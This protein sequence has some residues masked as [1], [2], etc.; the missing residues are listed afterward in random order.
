VVISALANIT[1][2]YIYRYMYGYERYITDQP[3]PEIAGGCPGHDRRDGRSD[4]RQPV[5]AMVFSPVPR[6]EGEA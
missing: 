1:S 6:R 2:G 4:K 3:V 5:V